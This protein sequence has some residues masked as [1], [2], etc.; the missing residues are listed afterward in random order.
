MDA[1]ARRRIRRPPPADAAE[2]TEGRES[3]PSRIGVAPL[4]LVGTGRSGSTVVARLLSRHERFAYLTRLADRHPERTGLA[5]LLLHLFELPLVGRLLW[6]RFNLHEAYSFWELHAKGFS[7]P[8]RDLVG[9]DVTDRAR[10]NLTG[11][12]E[13]LVTRRKPRFLA[14]LTGWGR[15]GYLREVFPNARFV[16]LVRDGRDVANSLLKVPFWKGW[17]G[18]GKW[19]FGPLP[20]HLEEAWEEHDRSF[21]VLAGLCWKMLVNAADGAGREL[22]A[23]RFLTVRYED[24]VAAPGK[25]LREILE[26]AGLEFTARVRKLAEEAD[27]F[28][29]SGKHRADLTEEQ[30][31]VL[32]DLLEDDL[33]YYGYL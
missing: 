31:S 27:I 12:V 10:R 14:K 24:F 17:E 4:F 9:R 5:R 21:V 28:D 19:R 23:D 13:G 30:Q 15:I 32:R 20:P 26:F 33:R 18:P 25:T 8:V 3:G 11:A 22:P 6:R 2:A 1:A 7:E 16:H 29:A